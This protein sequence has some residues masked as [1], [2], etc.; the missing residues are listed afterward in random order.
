MEIICSMSCLP[1]RPSGEILDDISA[2]GFTALDLSIRGDVPAELPGLLETSGLEIGSLDAGPLEAARLENLAPVLRWARG[3]GL[4]W[5]R[6]EAGPREQSWQEASALLTQAGALAD[7][8]GVTIELV[9]RSGT[10]LEQLEDYHRLQQEL[11]DGVFSLAL[12]AGE[13]HKASVNPKLA[14]VE[15]GEQ[16]SAVL[17]ADYQADQPVPLGTGQVNVRSVV[18][19]AERFN[20]ER[21]IISAPVPEGSDAAA[22]LSAARH[23]LESISPG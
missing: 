13:F 8:C 21:M 14:L 15:L 23:Y 2:A 17:L 18:I 5:V 11:P 4:I 3:L 12:D 10:R 20:V 22:W 1:G 19:Q 16:V 7:E 9:N 6:M